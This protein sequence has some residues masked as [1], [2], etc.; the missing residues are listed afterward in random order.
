MKD[1]KL[2]EYVGYP[3]T[4]DINQRLINLNIDN[5]RQVNK[6][7]IK[8]DTLLDYLGLEYDNGRAIL[9]KV[10]KKEKSNG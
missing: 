5:I 8:I 3:F 1:K 2:R 6:I 4:P 7:D 9:P 10:T